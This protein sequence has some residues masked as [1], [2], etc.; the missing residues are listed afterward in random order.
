[1]RVSYLEKRS[2]ADIGRRD[3]MNPILFPCPH[4][5]QSLAVSPDEAGRAVTC[6]QCQRT[7]LAP[8]PVT[9]GIAPDLGP[10]F[11]ETLRKAREATD[12]I[13]N[14]QD[15]DGD[16]LFG[17]NDTQRKP[18]DPPMT[19]VSTTPP[20]SDPHQRTVRLPDFPPNRNGF[21]TPTATRAAFVP[22]PVEV[23]APVLGN[24]FEDL[25]VDTSPEASSDL[26]PV[27]ESGDD[28]ED[29]F[30]ESEI[31]SFP[32]KNAGIAALAFYAILITGI[33][34]WG[35]LRTPDSAKGVP[36]ATANKH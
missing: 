19:P 36:P 3:I 10:D 8:V 12:S 22:T 25:S 30:E 29:A 31:R 5:S 14:D 1:M 28:E 24:P 33:A 7:V 6:P 15:D 18:I 4:C 11:T 32:W 34:A 27:E 9:V 16:S 17:G 13:F 26:P 2:A 20:K 35:W 21:H 23:P